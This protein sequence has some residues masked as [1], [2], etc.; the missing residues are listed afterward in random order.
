MKILLAIFGGL[1]V[2]FFYTVVSEWLGDLYNHWDYIK[3][4]KEKYNDH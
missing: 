3:H 1:C 2:G 4:K